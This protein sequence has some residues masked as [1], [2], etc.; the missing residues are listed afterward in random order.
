MYVIR[1]D[2]F[3]L[4]ELRLIIG[5]RGLME[6]FRQ[7]L[8][9]VL[10]WAIRVKAGCVATWLWVPVARLLL[11]VGLWVRSLGDFLVL[12]CRWLWGRR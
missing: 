11:A 1:L 7:E 5:S 4:D 10:V 2:C 3:I 12:V 8:P 9:N 6:V